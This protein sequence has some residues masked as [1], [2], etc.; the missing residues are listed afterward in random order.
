M[1]DA[2]DHR[3][4]NLLQANAR[5][6]NAEI[7]RRLKMAPSAILERIRRLEERGVIRGYAP[8]LDPV[9][10]GRGLL[11]FVFVRTDEPLDDARAAAG[12]A[13]LPEVLAVHDIAGEDCYLLEVRVAGTDELHRLLRHDIARV[14]SVRSTRTVIV[15]RTLK[16]TTALPI[17]AASE[18]DRHD[19]KRASGSRRRSR[20]ARR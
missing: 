9:A 6:S 8:Q 12:L 18:A 16:Q 4:L 17:G 15:L 11:A 10:V 3:I 13:A 1:N 14:P 5:T 20:R 2:I 19:R 7:A